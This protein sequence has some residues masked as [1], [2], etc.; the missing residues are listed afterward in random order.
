MLTP[1]VRECSCY[2][3][4]N[5]RYAGAVSSWAL[6]GA[7]WPSRVLPKAFTDRGSPVHCANADT[8]ILVS[9]EM[10]WGQM[11]LNYQDPRCASDMAGSRPGGELQRN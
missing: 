4:W 10:R 11:D 6:L 7:E 1:Q 5:L 8:C 2:K 9:G 3:R